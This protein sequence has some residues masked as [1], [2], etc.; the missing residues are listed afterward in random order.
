M[1]RRTTKPLTLLGGE[2]NVPPTAEAR[3][4]NGLPGCGIYE[5]GEV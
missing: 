2:I 4:G 3:E 5:G 1:N